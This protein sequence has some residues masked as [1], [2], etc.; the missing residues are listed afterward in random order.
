MLLRSAVLR[1]NLVLAEL[2]DPRR[3]AGF[4]VVTHIP[5]PAETEG[6]AVFDLC[7]PPTPF[8]S[9]AATEIEPHAGA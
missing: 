6:E 4:D 9:P 1:H 3:R 5:H 7:I 8:R 2:T